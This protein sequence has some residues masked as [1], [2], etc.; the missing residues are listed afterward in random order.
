MSNNT[1]QQKTCSGIAQN[2]FQP[3]ADE[4]KDCTQNSDANQPHPAKSHIC[5]LGG[6]AL[7]ESDM[8]AT[9]Q[10]LL[11][12]ASH[13][14]LEPTESSLELLH[15]ELTNGAQHTTQTT[16]QRTTLAS[17]QPQIIAGYSTGAFLLLR[18]IERFAPLL[19][20]NSRILLFAPFVDFRAESGLGGRIVATRLK[21]LLRRLRS[22]PL[23]AIADFYTQSGI[24]LSPP[25]T[26]PYALPDLLWGIEQ[27]AQTV[28][29]PQ[30]LAQLRNGEPPLSISAWIGASDALLDAQTI[31][32]H[33]APGVCRITDNA[34]HDLASMLAVADTDGGL[35]R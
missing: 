1:D 19:A 22:D 5:W 6:W 18:E 21:L 25:A 15:R 28:V 4:I 29:P 23:A 9:I 3:R 17:A 11:P 34:S 8:L 31:A 12:Q 26:L 35:L 2:E 7:A 27:L 10:Q 30:A 32:T 33:F 13:R 20:P 24:A 14:V 16:A